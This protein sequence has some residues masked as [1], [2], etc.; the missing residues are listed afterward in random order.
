MSASLSSNHHTHKHT[1][2]LSVQS[3]R[4]KCSAPTVAMS[5]LFQAPAFPPPPN[6]MVYPT[7]LTLITSPALLRKPPRGEF[8]L[9]PGYNFTSLTAESEKQLSTDRNV[10]QN[11][12]HI[13][14][15]EAVSRCRWHFGSGVAPEKK[16][17]RHVCHMVSGPL[18][19][20]REVTFICIIHGRPDVI[21]MCKG[22]KSSVTKMGHS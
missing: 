5:A 2:P 1:P 10:E 3:H 8:T 16:K 22:A 17:K 6:L 7:A 15:R 18:G 4:F 19:I 13:C 11:A 9:Q 12:V 20:T 21:R 14:C